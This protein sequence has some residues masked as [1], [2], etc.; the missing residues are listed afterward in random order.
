MFGR[1]LGSRGRRQG[2]GRLG[3]S[4]R[5]WAEARAVFLI[6]VSSLAS[7]LVCAVAG[8]ICYGAHAYPKVG[9]L[10]VAYMPTD[11]TPALSKW[12]VVGLT[13]VA[14]NY[15]PGMAETL[16]GLNPDIILIAYFPVGIIWANPDTTD[17]TIGPFWRKVQEGD[18]W[19][20][21]N[22]GNRLL[23]RDDYYFLNLS[24]K[25]PR[26]QSGQTLA[27]WVAQY[28]ADHVM[29]TGFWDGVIL[30]AASG[31]IS[32]VNNLPHLFEE[33]PA[34][35]D[36]DGD[37]LVDDRDSLDLWWKTGAETCLAILRREAGPSA[38]ILPNGHNTFYQYANGGIRE[39]FPNT[40]G[41]WEASMFGPYGYISAC[42]NYLDQPVNLT[43]IWCYWDDQQFDL[44]DAPTSAS[45]DRFNRFTLASAML[46][47]GYYFLDGT[48]AGSLW[49]RDYYDLDVGTPLG[50]AYLDSLESPFDHLEHPVWRRDFTNADVVCNPY[51]QYLVLE[52]NTWLYPE[53]GVIRTTLL[54]GTVSISLNKRACERQFDRRQRGLA[55][56]VTVTNPNTKAAQPYK[57]A[58][59]VGPQGTVASALPTIGLVGAQ[60]SDTLIVGLKVPSALP[61]GEYCLRVCAAGRDLV[62]VSVDTMYVAK[63]IEFEK[64]G[65]PVDDDNTTGYI[66]LE[67]DGLSIYP[68]PAFFSSQSALTMEVNELTSVE[69]FCSIKI[70]DV[71]GRLLDTVFEG[72]LEKGLVLAIGDDQGGV[73]SVPGVYFLQIETRDKTRTQKVVLLK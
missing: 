73:L 21:D 14:Q 10:F 39:N 59:L 51:Q 7:I 34:G 6:I 56:E 47:D 41:G 13:V 40:P 8:S 46:G 49:W 9:N 15:L 68:Q 72:R 50:A 52:D 33:L 35:V 12:D 64:E 67:E 3:C 17:P 63:V 23:Y 19:L 71:S 58:E 24:A 20:R 4:L 43:M 38:I 36:C 5:R 28:V 45:F 26:D 2:G 54:P 66:H 29:A 32:W 25:C 55:F 42:E 69:G 57:W 44:F 60:A 22:R 16:R 61:V 18:W 37:C 65:K 31:Q 30:D 1:A 62:P 11:Y 53:D 48:H 70:Y 27:E